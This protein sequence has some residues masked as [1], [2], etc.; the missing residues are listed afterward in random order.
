LTVEFFYQV[1]NIAFETY[2]TGQIAVR[3]IKIQDNSYLSSGD[4]VAV[5][6]EKAVSSFIEVYFFNQRLETLE[7]IKISELV[8]PGRPG[9]LTPQFKH[10]ST[11]FG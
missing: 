3:F 9:I 5:F 7:V 11:F 2:L 4:Y 8:I 6:K 1:Y 10:V